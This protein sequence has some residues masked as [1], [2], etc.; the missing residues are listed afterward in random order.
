[1]PLPARNGAS[2]TRCHPSGDPPSHAGHGLWGVSSTPGHWPRHP[3]LVASPTTSPVPAAHTLGI[4]RP[5]GSVV[6]PA[7]IGVPDQSAG[8][9]SPVRRRQ[10]HLARGSRM[11]VDCTSFHSSPYLQLH[12]FHFTAPSCHIIGYDLSLRL[13]RGLSPYE[14]PCI[15]QLLHER[16][17][18][19]GVP[20]RTTLSGCLGLCEFVPPAYSHLCCWWVCCM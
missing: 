20:Y 13:I 1:M 16:F 11:S 6:G 3:V 18:I 19:S 12:H 14:N 2:V 8:A 9:P 15:I 4:P 17:Y 10:F 5:G 7:T